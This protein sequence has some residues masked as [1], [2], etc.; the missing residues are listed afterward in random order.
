MSAAANV[1]ARDGERLGAAIFDFDGTLYD[2]RGLIPKIIMS[3]PLNALTMRAEREARRGMHGHDYGSADALRSDLFRRVAAITKRSADEVRSWYFGWYLPCIERILK[4]RFRA[5]R[6]ADCLMESLRVM[7]VKTAVLSDY[8]KI[9]ERLEA[10]GLDSRNFDVILS[11]ED[12]GALKPCPRPFIETAKALG[13]PP[14]QCLVAGDRSDTDGDGARAAGMGFARIASNRG[15]KPRDAY[16]DAG[17]DWDD[18][19]RAILMAVE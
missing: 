2:M 3:S 19:S 17:L 7:G 9:E 15:N 11:A 18:F 16:K 13:V 12:L 14:C 5:R 10:I 4:K 8:P 6:N 1:G